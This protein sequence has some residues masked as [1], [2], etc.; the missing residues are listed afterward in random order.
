[1]TLAQFAALLK[2]AGYPVALGHFPTT[3]PQTPPYVVYIT[4]Q[5]DNFAADNRVYYSTPLVQV[6]L[7]T[8]NKDLTAEGKVETALS[9]FFWTKN[10]GDLPEEHLHM[11]TYQL[12]L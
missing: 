10:E 8:A 4:P 7:Y 9:S 6:E 3:A 5:A 1:M 11:V 12:T 2:T